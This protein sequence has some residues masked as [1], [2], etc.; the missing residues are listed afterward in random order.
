VV[1]L[2][3]YITSSR[4]DA[5]SASNNSSGRLIE[6]RPAFVFRINTR[7]LGRL[8]G[9]CAAKRRPVR[10]GLFGVAH[11]CPNRR[12]WHPTT[13][14]SQVQIAGAMVS[15][16][17]T[18]DAALVLPVRGRIHRNAVFTRLRGALLSA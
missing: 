12:F 2:R 6:S 1:A 5:Q 11:R 16:L 10:R 4:D 8:P 18:A 15:F 3:A 17:S 14:T 9:R 13:V 7:V